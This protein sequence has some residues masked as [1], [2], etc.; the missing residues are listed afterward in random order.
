MDKYHVVKIEALEGVIINTIIGFINPED[1]V[2][3]ENIHGTPMSDWANENPNLPLVDYF[4][5]NSPCYLIDSTYDIKEGVSL[6]TNLT[7]P[8]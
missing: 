8:E 3:F 7:T 5:T 1:K 6:I 4:D 2:D